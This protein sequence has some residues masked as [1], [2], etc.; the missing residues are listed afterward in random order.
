MTE[1]RIIT[2]PCNPDRLKLLASL[3]ANKDGSKILFVLEGKNTV[4]VYVQQIQREDG[5][6]YNFNV[7]GHDVSTN[8][9]VQIY[10]NTNRREG[11]ITFFANFTPLGRRPASAVV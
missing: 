10:Y 4:R 2:D 1:A 6:G 9:P 5:S 7:T 8:E 11:H 3:A